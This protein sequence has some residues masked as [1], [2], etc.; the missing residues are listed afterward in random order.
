VLAEFN[1]GQ[2]FQHM[3]RGQHLER[4]GRLDEA[5]TEFKRAIEADPSIAAAHNALGHHYHRKGFLTRAVDEFHT[6]ALLSRDYQSCFHL[7]RALTDLGRHTEA[8]EAFRQCLAMDA[9]APSARY[10]LAYAQYAQGQFAEALAQFQSLAEEFPEDWELRS[11]IAD[12]HMGS[13][14]YEQAERTLC[15]ALRSAPATTDTLTVREAVLAARRHLEFPPQQALGLKDLMYA[16][17][18]VMSLGSG[19][20]DGL[21]IPVYQDYTFTYSDVAMT[22]SR[23]MTVIREYNWQFTA[24]VSVDADSMPLA[25]ALSQL[26]E[27]P[28]LRVEELGEDDFALVVLA[29]GTQPE[30][31]E[32]TLEHIP[33]RMVSFALAWQPHEELVTDILGVQC[34]GK[35]RLPWN[36]LRKR[37]A[38]AAATSILRAL[39]I[40]PDEDNRPQQ[41]AYYTRGHK[42]LRFCD[43]SAEFAEHKGR[44]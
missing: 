28:V 43:L 20:D 32:V 2:A 41:V 19:R 22:C 31:C 9:G 16:N 26:L 24:L 40:V 37:S 44:G 14:D 11:A 6:A 35:C 7:G 13:K 17:H 21:D 36:R 34:S 29:M 1:H 15:E 18:G 42:L 8:E 10:E 4:Q 38:L 5:M 27:Q 23:L 33:D 3:E 30:L 12:C 39:A 25:I